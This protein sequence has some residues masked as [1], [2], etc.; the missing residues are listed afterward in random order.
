MIVLSRQL[1]G[2]VWFENRLLMAVKRYVSV[3]LL[4][5]LKKS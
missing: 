1:A 4:R 5:C 3:F 2:K